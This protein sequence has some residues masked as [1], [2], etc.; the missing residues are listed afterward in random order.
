MMFWGLWHVLVDFV[1]GN[2]AKWEKN[3]LLGRERAKIIIECQ[4]PSIST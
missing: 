4:C 2:F 1:F 3:L